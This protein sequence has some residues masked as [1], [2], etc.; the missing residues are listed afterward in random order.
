MAHDDCKRFYLIKTTKDSTLHCRTKDHKELRF[1]EV[2]QCWCWKQ[3]NDRRDLESSPKSIKSGL[4]NSL[5]TKTGTFLQ[6]REEEREAC[7]P[8]I[9]SVQIFA[10]ISP[11]AAHSSKRLSVCGQT[12]QDLKWHFHH[13]HFKFQTV[14]DVIDL[15]NSRRL[16]NHTRIC[17]K[18]SHPATHLGLP[19]W[20]VM[21]KQIFVLHVGLRM[22]I[23]I[24][25]YA[26][27]AW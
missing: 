18:H 12:C 6:D 4:K 22:V 16:K 27:T 17:E 1:Q 26:S 10:H 19:Q 3:W 7:F 25:L 15:V 5:S 20:K 13:K 8:S 9:N 23:S 11:D 21:T 24:Y 2:N 14:Q